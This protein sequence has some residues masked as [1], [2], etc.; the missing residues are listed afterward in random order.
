M[1]IITIIITNI[2]NLRI[3]SNIRLTF[4][5][6]EYS[7]IRPTPNSKDCDIDNVRLSNCA[8]KDAIVYPVHTMQKL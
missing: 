5:Y 6:T 8:L 1:H 7:N 3:Y 4:E 2:R